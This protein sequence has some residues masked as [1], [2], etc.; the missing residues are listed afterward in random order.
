VFLGGGFKL[1]WFQFVA[2]A[3]TL[4]FSFTVSFV[5]A[6]VID[7]VIGLR[8]SEEDEYEGLDLSQHAESAYSFGSTG[9][10]DRI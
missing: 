5:I 10:M 8:V 1:L 2:C 4:A 6:K 7:M 3:A 9:T